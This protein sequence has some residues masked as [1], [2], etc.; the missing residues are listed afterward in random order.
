[1]VRGRLPYMV[2][3]RLPYPG[4]PYHHTTLGIPPASRTCP[5][6]ATVTG[7]ATVRGDNALGSSWEKAL[8]IGLPAPLILLSC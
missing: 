1:M 4:I 8:G 6:Y 2:G 5:L 3:G 7:V